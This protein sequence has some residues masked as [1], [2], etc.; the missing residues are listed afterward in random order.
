M[1]RRRR[2]L[3]AATLALL[4][5]P[6]MAAEPKVVNVYNWSDYVAEDTLENFTAASGIRV[7]YDVYDANETLE[8]KLLAGKSGYDV[9][10]PSAQPFA[11]R[12]IAAGVYQPLDRAKLPH[13]PNLDPDILK[14][15]EKVDPGNRHVVPYMWGT[16]GIGYNVQRVAEALGDEAPVDSLRML[17][18]PEVVSRLAGC[19]VTLMDDEA[20]ALGAA[21]IYLGKSVNTTD[22]RDIEA[23]AEL[24][25]KVR[26]HVRYF[27]SSQYINDLA[28]GDI[29]VAQGY[30]GDVLQAR[31]RADEAGN[32][33]EIG[34][35]IPREGAIMWVD[36]MAIP[37]DAPHPGNA[38]AFI[39]FLLRPEVIAGIS[40]YVSYANA[41]LAATPQVDEEVRD[42]PN[43]YPP[44]EVKARLVATEVP[45]AEIQR[46]RTR[47]W[48]RVKTGR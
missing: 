35:A 30:S 6:T 18:D 3:L 9:I 38:H 1:S 39:D 33:V 8:A 45:S 29:C 28:N 14:A 10:F 15:L 22:P 42:D 11:Q 12:H 2:T 4:S 25:L 32:G 41:N 7:I 43:I 37:K 34:Y 36:V 26:P 17:F 24:I 19:G 48:T 31:D 47:T 46:L 13:Y 44:P 5:A 20:E 40:N 27:H 23:A 21:L 16:T